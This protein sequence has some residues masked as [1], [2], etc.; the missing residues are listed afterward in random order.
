[1]ESPF[2]FHRLSLTITVADDFPDFTIFHCMNVKTLF[3]VT[4]NDIDE[5]H[6]FAFPFSPVS[7]ISLIEL[8][9]LDS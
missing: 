2:S 1:M 3:I 8:A 7:L 4:L 5:N 6:R 9:V